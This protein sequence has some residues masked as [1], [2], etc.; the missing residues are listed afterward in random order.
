MFQGV[1][2]QAFAI[3]LGQ[4]GS[5]FLSRSC[6]R[7]RLQGPRLQASHVSGAALPCFLPGPCFSVRFLPLPHLRA[8]CC[9]WNV[10]QRLTSGN[11]SPASTLPTAYFL[12]PASFPLL[13]FTPRGPAGPPGP[14]VGH[15]PRCSLSPE[16]PA[17]RVPIAV[18]ALPCSRRSSQ[19]MGPRHPSCCLGGNG[20][21][22]ASGFP[23]TFLSH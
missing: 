7:D 16:T 13:L 19:K 1:L 12:L 23:R 3:G 9:P 14:G 5:D 2:S 15:A 17:S 18:R 20:D 22:S 11:T 6:C 21:T 4:R 8:V 10:L